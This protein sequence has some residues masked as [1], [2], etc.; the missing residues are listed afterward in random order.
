MEGKKMNVN[1]WLAEMGY[2]ERNAT[3]KIICAGGWHSEE[4]R[5][6]IKINDPE[7]YEALKEIFKN[8]KHHKH[9]PLEVYA[10]GGFFVPLRCFR[11]Q[12][13]SIPRRA[14]TT[15]APKSRYALFGI[16]SRLQSFFSLA[17]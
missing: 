9:T 13:H 14:S 8:N 10:S 16:L 17:I 7:K 1:K 5:L 6:Y 15:R 3:Q 12:R 4:E 11:R 2:E